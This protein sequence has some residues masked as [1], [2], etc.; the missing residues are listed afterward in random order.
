M[1][2]NSVTISKETITRLL[3][4][5]RQIMKNPLIDNGIYYFHDDEDLL[6]GYAMIVGPSDTPYF[7]GFYFFKFQY[8]ADYPYS[9][10][11]VTYHTNDGNVRFNPN[12]YVNGKVCVSILN[13]WRGE[14]WSS[15]QTIST[16]LLT[17]CT[18]FVQHP[19][20]NEPG[21]LI[22]NPDNKPYNEI[23]KYSNIKIAICNMIKKKIGIFMPEFSIFS[24]YMKENF[25]KNADKIMEFL[26]TQNMDIYLIK[27]RMY[28]M[29]IL[30]DYKIVL[31]DFLECKL[32]LEQN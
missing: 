20:V 7:G 5:V 17:L 3:K 18:L 12:L 31:Q 30:I 25:L 23:I 13:T 14:Q 15:C 26:K 24:P 16:I 19:I 29:N 21:I 27:T 32:M 10:P 28:N 6:K 9:P 8:T 2:S 22:T 11:V 4:D 1:T